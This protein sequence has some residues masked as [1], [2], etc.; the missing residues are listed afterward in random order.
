MATLDAN[1]SLALRRVAAMGLAQALFPYV[2]AMVLC[3]CFSTGRFTCPRR[4]YAILSAM[5]TM[6]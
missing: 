2:L 3:G 4:T 1:L 6:A 5:A